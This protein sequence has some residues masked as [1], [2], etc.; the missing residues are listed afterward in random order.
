MYNFYIILI[1]LMPKI[2]NSSMNFKDCELAI[3]R[4]AVDQIEERVGK[5]KID[6][7]EVTVIISIVEEFLQKRK[8]ICYG[9]TAINNILPEKDQFYNKDVELPDYDFFSPTPLKDAKDLADI[10]YKRGFTE[11]QAS[12]GVHTGTFKVFVNFMPVADI[13]YLVPE[14]YKNLLKKAV[15]I[16]GIRYCPPN[17]L[18]MLMY[19]ELSRPRGDASRWEKVLKRLTILNDNYPLVASRCDVTLIQRIFEKGYKVKSN[20]MGGVVMDEDSFE[21][22]EEKIFMIARETLS[23]LG[24]IFFGAFANRLFLKNTKELKRKP[25]PK[26]PDFDVLSVEPERHANILK[27]RLIHSNIRKVNIV[28]RPGVGE[29]IAPHFEVRIGKETVAFIYEPLACHSY[30][31]IEIGGNN[32]KIAT[33]DTMLSFYLAFLFTDRP[34]YNE[35]RI[36]CMSHY[37]F[38]VQEKNRLKQK[39]LLKRFSIDCYGNHHT[40]EEIRSE[41]A[42]MFKTLKKMKITSGKKYEWYFLKYTPGGKNK[43]PTKTKTKKKKRKRRKK[44]TRKFLF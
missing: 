43:K 12:A 21:N 39:G 25:I 33:L 10:Y 1:Y 32:Y 14:L 35:K 6:N 38:E 13:T 18:R 41:K 40:I 37:L 36:L 31:Q 34:Y 42:E 17:Y 15:N 29:I 3:L 11:V 44:K 30:N 24:C 2:C 23:S 9:G 19:L 26:I 22:P 20:S 8:R 16:A 7:P 5:Q 28:K 4:N 27:E